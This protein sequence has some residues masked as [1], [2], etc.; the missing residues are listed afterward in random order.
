MVISVKIVSKVADDFYHDRNKLV[1]SHGLNE[2]LEI[3]S[4]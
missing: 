1:Q 2:G 3:K 4:T